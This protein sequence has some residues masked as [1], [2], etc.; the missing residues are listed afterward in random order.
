MDPVSPQKERTIRD[1]FVDVIFTHN[2]SDPATAALAALLR[3]LGHANEIPKDPRTLKRKR[4]D[5]PG[6]Q[7]FA[8]FGLVNGI[9]LRLANSCLT[10]GSDK[11]KLQV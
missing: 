2:L 7:D 4:R 1:D 8:H 11:I 3:K 9:K 6:A 5:D 10:D